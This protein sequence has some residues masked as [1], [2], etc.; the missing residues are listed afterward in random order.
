MD[1]N[2]SGEIWY[3]DLVLYQGR[4]CRLSHWGECLCLY[5]YAWC[6]FKHFELLLHVPFIW[7]CGQIFTYIRFFNQSVQILIDDLWCW[8]SWKRICSGSHG[9]RRGRMYGYGW[10]D[11]T[12]SGWL[13]KIILEIK[14][15]H[16]SNI[17][18]Q[19][20]FSIAIRTAYEIDEIGGQS[21]W[22]K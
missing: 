20:P 10:S 11:R 19:F 22:L 8:W 1:I 5:K 6:I 13:E 18:A 17:K 4:L 2:A 9:G 7:N 3:C 21:T 16:F 12:W 14:R 15:K